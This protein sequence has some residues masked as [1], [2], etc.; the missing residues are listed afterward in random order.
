M[1]AEFRTG[2]RV[3][4]R[5]VEKHRT[6]PV[7]RNPFPGT[8]T[9]VGRKYVYVRL[10][11]KTHDIK[12]RLA[13]PHRQVFDEGYA[14]DYVLYN[15]E[16]AVRNYWH[17]LFAIRQLSDGLEKLRRFFED[18]HEDDLEVVCREVEEA[19]SALATSLL[20]ARRNAQ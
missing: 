16:E 8:V 4:A 10:D 2:Q 3:F 18:L 5:R 11:N 6:T 12:F 1:S 19:E 7:P 15:D 14:P 9:K 17:A 13:C 20:F